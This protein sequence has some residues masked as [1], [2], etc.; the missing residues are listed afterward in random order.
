MN[1]DTTKKYGI[2]LLI[3][4][5][6]MLSDTM[7]VSANYNSQPSPWQEWMDSDPYIKELPTKNG[8]HVILY[9][10]FSNEE[11]ENDAVTIKLEGNSEGMERAINMY[12][13]M[14]YEVRIYNYVMNTET[15]I[16][17]F[18]GQLVLIKN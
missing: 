8:D 15:G 12:R 7:H 1:L 11:I 5:M 13:S 9:L 18:V 2:V 10:S 6:V 4:T 17:E 14:G 3:T 16:S